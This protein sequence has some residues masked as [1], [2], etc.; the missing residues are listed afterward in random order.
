[1]R[2]GGPVPTAPFTGDHVMFRGKFPQLSNL[3]H[4]AIAAEMFGEP[5]NNANVEVDPAILSHKKAINVYYA[6]NSA[7]AVD[8]TGVDPADGESIDTI[9]VKLRNLS[10][11]PTSGTS[12]SENQVYL[13]EIT[14]PP[15]GIWHK[16][17]KAK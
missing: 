14:N 16:F 7:G 6:D 5:S 13:G 4:K 1:V 17:D 12:P 10:A 11:V 8:T 15:T 9:L 2:F 3:R